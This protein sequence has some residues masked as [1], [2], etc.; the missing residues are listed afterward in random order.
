MN[1][2]QIKFKEAPEGVAEIQQFENQKHLSDIVSEWEKN[3]KIQKSKVS[4]DQ[5][6]FHLPG[7]KHKTVLDITEAIPVE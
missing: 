7:D 2:L 4:K 6:E 5:I 3:G 1:K